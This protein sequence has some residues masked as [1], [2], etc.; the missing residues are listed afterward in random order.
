MYIHYFGAPRERGALRAA[1]YVRY[2]SYGTAYSQR[3]LEKKY[4]EPS[5]ICNVATVFRYNF[6]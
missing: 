5:W 6:I 2:V 1:R 4:M 3:H